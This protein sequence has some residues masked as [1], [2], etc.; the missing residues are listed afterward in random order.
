MSLDPYC[1]DSSGYKIRNVYYDTEADNV[2]RHSLSKPYFKEK[3]RLRF[4]EEPVDETSRLFIELK[5][6]IDG[7]VTK[8]R[9]SVNLGE[10]KEFF[11][12]HIPPEREKYGEKQIL[13]ELSA[14]L[15]ANDVMPKVY[16]CYDRI[17]FFDKENKA[18]RITFDY[19]ITARRIDPRS[20]SAG[21]PRELIP[22]DMMLMEI[23]FSNSIPLWIAQM[24]SENGIYKTSF[25]KYGTEYKMTLAD[26]L[27]SSQNQE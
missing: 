3:L 24:L 4:Y 12:T 14:Y 1:T 26:R 27:G 2:I 23:K 20:F 19:G 8:R 10:L 9:A 5:R 18:I 13:N 11:S 6:K 16:L 22:E 17:A 15:S 21:E 25:S 7:I